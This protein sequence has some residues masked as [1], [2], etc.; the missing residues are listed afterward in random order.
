MTGILFRCPVV[1]FSSKEKADVPLVS[2]I[3]TL[4][5]TKAVENIC[6]VPIIRFALNAPIR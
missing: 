5:P 3:L 2:S 4:E 6:I 1:G